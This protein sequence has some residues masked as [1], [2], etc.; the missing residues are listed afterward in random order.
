MAKERIL[1][2]P[3]LL[4][5][6]RLAAFPVTLFLALSGHERAFVVLICISLVTDVLDGLIARTFHL[7]TRFGAALDNAADLGTY[8]VAL[9]GLLRFRWQAVRPHAWLLFAFVGALLFSYGVAWIRF[10]KFP[11]LHLLSGVIKAYL[12]GIFFF[13]LFARG[14]VP[15]LFYLAGGFG[16]LAYAEKTT[17]LFLLDDIKPKVRGLY[18]LLRDRR[19]AVQ[20]D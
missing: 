20:A 7:E 8:A 6:Y 14:F 9:Y 3:N 12:Q 18:W 10:R 2:V 1:N 5:G 13:V 17:V 15:W 11:G 19:R 4:S 16:I